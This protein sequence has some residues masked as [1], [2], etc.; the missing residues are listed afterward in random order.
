MSR[1][2]WAYQQKCPDTAAPNTPS[3]APVSPALHVACVASAQH[4]LPAPAWHQAAPWVSTTISD[5]PPQLH[6]KVMGY[7]NA[8]QE[9][10]LD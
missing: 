3:A 2:K 8:R 4:S 5:V 7:N 9:H 1:E 6:K 10:A